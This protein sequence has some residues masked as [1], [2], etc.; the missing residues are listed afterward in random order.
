MQQFGDSTRAAL[1]DAEIIEAIA[2]DEAERLAFQRDFGPMIEQEQLEAAQR[3]F[4]QDFGPLV[5][6]EVANTR[7]RQRAEFENDF[8]RFETEAEQERLTEERLARGRF[9]REF[10]GGRD[11]VLSDAE[12]AQQQADAEAFGVGGGLDQPWLGQPSELLIAMQ[13]LPQGVL[14]P[15]STFATEE[16]LGFSGAYRN[17]FGTPLTDALKSSMTLGSGGDLPRYTENGVKIVENCTGLC[18]DFL[19][20]FG[21]DAITLGNTIFTT[22]TIEAGSGLESE[23]LFHVGQQEACMTFQDKPVGRSVASQPL[24]S[25]PNAAE[26]QISNRGRTSAVGFNNANPTA[27]TTNEPQGI[28]GALQRA[29]HVSRVAAGEVGLQRQAVSFRLRKRASLAR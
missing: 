23:E 2:A 3:Q 26:L 20:F 17:I 8:G 12:L 28:N 6:R 1:T 15:N 27:F 14:D 7:N 9:E 21:E 13:S 11:R 22:G 5:E 19:D 4:T 29:K 24:V 10:G 25:A 18:K 16:P